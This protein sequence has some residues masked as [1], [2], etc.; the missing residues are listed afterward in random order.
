M[1]E[2]YYIGTDK[3]L[4]PLGGSSDKKV[5]Q[6]IL[7][8]SGWSSS[9]IQSLTIEG[10]SAD[11]TKQIITIIPSK[12]Q[13]VPFKKAGIYAYDQNINEISFICDTIP[14]DDLTIFIEVEEISY[15]E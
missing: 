14:S 1:A 3:T 12:E 13:I 6:K 11:E 4:Y 8:K 10:I 7:T 5:Y 9:K 15:V 2:F